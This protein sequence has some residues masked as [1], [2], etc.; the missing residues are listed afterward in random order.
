MTRALKPALS[1]V[2]LTALVFT[3]TLA[4]SAAHA[5]KG[6]SEIYQQTYEFDQP[7]H[8]YEGHASHR[9]YC[10][11]K[12]FP[13]RKCFVLKNGREKCKVVGWELEQ[14]CY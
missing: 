9:K 4:T 7:M 1:L 6:S 10:T 2:S 11:Y 13:Q 8:G 12:R 5:G 14:T 3:M